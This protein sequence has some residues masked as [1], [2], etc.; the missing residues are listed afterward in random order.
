M[1]NFYEMSNTGGSMR[2]QKFYKIVLFGQ[3]NVSRFSARKIEPIA[4]VR[5]HCCVVNKTQTPKKSV[6]DKRRTSKTLPHK[7]QILYKSV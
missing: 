1:Y 2:R 5:L 4:P 7:V 6:V 3:E